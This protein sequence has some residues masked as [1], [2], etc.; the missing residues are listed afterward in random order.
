MD[1]VQTPK[2][3]PFSLQ[4]P[5]HFLQKYFPLVILLHIK[6]LL[7]NKIVRNLSLKLVNEN[8]LQALF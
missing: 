4:L 6:H 5:D 3:R 2:S 7:G 8:I 1:Q